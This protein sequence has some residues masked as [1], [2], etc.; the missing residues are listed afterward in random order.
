MNHSSLPEWKLERYALGELPPAELRQI[1]ARIAQDPLLRER[2]EAL[3]RSNRDLLEQ[4]PPAW[5]A[6]QL[7]PVSHRRIPFARVSRW[8]APALLVMAALVLAPV[9]LIQEPVPE[10]RSKGLETR[11]EVW[12]QV[13]DSAELLKPN[14]TAR[15][16]D[17]VQ[18]RYVVPEPCYGALL[19]LDGRGVVT[20]HLAASASSAVPL[21]PGRAISLDRSYQLDDAPLYETFYLITSRKDFELAPLTES[22]I[23]AAQN[24]VGVP[25]PVLPKGHQA[26]TFT[27]HKIP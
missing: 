20:I 13:G 1:G 8:L 18:L 11:L 17:V 12:R 22:L 3:R 23:K 16:G 9:L 26:Q 19:S 14:S 15:N 5:M 27:L 7:K 2:L 10:I 4:Y 6:R 21:Q 24:H 25:A